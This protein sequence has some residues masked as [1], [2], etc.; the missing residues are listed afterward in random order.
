MDPPADQM[1]DMGL[2]GVC[3]SIVISDGAGGS[4]KPLSGFHVFQQQGHIGMLSS[5]AR[6]RQNGLY[7]NIE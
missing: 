3:T 1:L 6:G 7:K 2:P 4:L 5:S